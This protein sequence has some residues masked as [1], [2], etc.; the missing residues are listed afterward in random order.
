MSMLKYLFTLFLS[1]SLFA[2]SS[3]PLFDEEGGPSEALLELYDLYGVEHLGTW[4]SMLE[5]TLQIANRDI[6]GWELPL[7]EGVDKV[8]AFDLYNQLGVFD[9][10]EAT[11]I[12]YDFGVVLGSAYDTVVQRLE[13]LN[14][15][16]EA[17]VRFDTLV[18]LT[19]DRKLATFE[20]EKLS[21]TVTNETEMM[22]LLFHELDLPKQWRTLPLVVI[23]TP[24]AEGASRPNTTDTYK[25][26]RET[27]P[28]SGSALIVSSQPF[29]ARQEAVAHK[30]LPT[31]LLIETIG[32][33]AS[34]ESFDS[35]PRAVETLFH[36]LNWWV[37]AATT[38]EA[39]DDFWLHERERTA[40][41]CGTDT[42]TKT[43][44]TIDHTVAT[45]PIDPKKIK[46]AVSK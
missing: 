7:I 35:H 43:M 17:G 22:I 29:I 1:L 20:I 21:E 34:R 39:S 16:W 36:N 5:I 31:T 24:P 9:E 4:D 44:S 38:D 41:A 13:F 26:W 12:H 3:S 32:P 8:R 23:D 14:K 27:M 15:Q 45:L 28:L 2:G 10:V 30:Y 18:F 37:Y 19:G 6:V 46:A 33:G 42:K 25:L 40:K 11:H